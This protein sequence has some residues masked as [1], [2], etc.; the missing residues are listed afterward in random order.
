M[1]TT[2][3]QLTEGTPTEEE[4]RE[5]DVPWPET[6]DELVE[7]IDGLT[8]RE[9][10]YATCVYAM[11]MAAVAAFYYVAKKLGVT[12]FQA[13][14][15]DMDVLRRTRHIEHGFYLREYEDL[16]Y[17]Q[18][19]DKFEKTITLDTWRDLQEAAQ[20]RLDEPASAATRVREHWQGI[21]DGN[22]PHGF[23]IE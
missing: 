18:Y 6:T 23:V 15:A 1:S 14:M 17:P 13:S 2:N 16:L 3:G 11:S 10:D 21:V 20:K 7:Y 8:E 19:A 4:M 9:H 5:A 12:G 22:V